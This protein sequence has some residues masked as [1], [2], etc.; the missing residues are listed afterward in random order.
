MTNS[1]R[2]P[3]PLD[4]RALEDLALWQDY[5]RARGAMLPFLSLSQPASRY[6][7]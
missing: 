1:R 4:R 5:D 7:D 3:P 2:T 6:R